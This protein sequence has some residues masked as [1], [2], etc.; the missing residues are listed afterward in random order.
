[1]RVVRRG[2]LLFAVSFVFL[3]G[4]GTNTTPPITTPA[5]GCGGGMLTGTL[6]D[7]ITNQPVSRGV[8]ILEQGSQLGTTSNWNFS[9]TQQA[10]TDSQG[11]FSFCAQS[12]SYPTVLVLEAMNTSGEAYPS[13]VTQVT[14]ASDIGNIVMGGC[15]LNC[16]LPGVQQTALPATITG[17]VTSSPLAA[18]G[19]IIPRFAMLAL[20]DSKAADGARNTWSIAMTMFPNAQS[21]SFSTVAG[22]CNGAAPFCASYAFTVPVQSPFF[23][24][25]G[26]MARLAAAPVYLVFAD[27]VPATCAPSFNFAVINVS[28]GAQIATPPI[29]LANC[30]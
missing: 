17:T 29:N 6:R 19:T 2:L 11:A 9:P 26:G 25:A 12:F 27:A 28:A 7:S 30:K 22:N 3:P 21:T 8:A 4:C 23:P 1:M 18:S 14:G 10:A 24:V 15:N 20:D 5:P 13:Y 16:G